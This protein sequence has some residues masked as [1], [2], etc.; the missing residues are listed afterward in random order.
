MPS[1][2]ARRAGTR[3]LIAIANRGSAVER[4]APRCAC[5]RRPRTRTRSCRALARPYKPLKLLRQL[6]EEPIEC[7]SR[8]PHS[9]SEHPTI[10]RSSAGGLSVGGKRNPRLARSSGANGPAGSCSAM[11]VKV[12][13]GA[14]TY[15]QRG[16]QPDRRTARSRVPARRTQARQ[17]GLV[18]ARRCARRDARSAPVSR[19]S[20]EQDHMHPAPG[21]TRQIALE[22]G[23]TS[24]PSV[25]K[26][27]I[28]LHA[29]VRPSKPAG[30]PS[31][32]SSCLFPTAI[33]RSGRAAEGRAVGVGRG[34]DDLADSAAAVA[35]RQWRLQPRGPTW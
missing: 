11:T 31:R 13:F 17:P 9:W 2:A 35:M 7:S 4:R 21:G 15:R 34:R 32:A 28:R 30:T 20:G 16:R 24:R 29:R 8:Q 14:G 22:Y 25:D 26:L 1:R 5:A 6:G 19:P 12:V 18:T 3:L 10:E 23:L 27:Q 33:R